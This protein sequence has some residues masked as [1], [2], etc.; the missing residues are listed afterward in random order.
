[1]VHDGTSKRLMILQVNKPTNPSGSSGDEFRVFRPIRTSC[2]CG[3]REV[4]AIAGGKT[5]RGG[6]ARRGEGGKRAFI[7]FRCLMS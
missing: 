2:C 1:M 5:T 4:A 6:E 7:P 3:R